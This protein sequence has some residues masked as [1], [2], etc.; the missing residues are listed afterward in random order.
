MSVFLIALFALFCFATC[1]QSDR[2][3]SDRNDLMSRDKPQ[4]CSRKE[5]ERLLSG[6]AT[7]V[8]SELDRLFTENPIIKFNNMTIKK[9]DIRD[10]IQK[11]KFK[12]LVNVIDR[13]VL[14][15][16]KK[17]WIDLLSIANFKDNQCIVG[18]RR[19]VI[20]HMQE[21]KIDSWEE[22][23]FPLNFSQFCSQQEILKLQNSVKDLQFLK[24]DQSQG[25]DRQS[26]D[27]DDRQRQGGDRQR[28]PIETDG[29]SHSQ[30]SNINKQPDSTTTSKSSAS[31]SSQSQDTSKPA[32]QEKVVEKEQPSGNQTE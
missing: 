17:C 32:V 16:N 15:N 12:T 2:L 4:M 18:A 29:S 20:L 23:M 26:I 13:P 3:S 30:S 11:M 5:L 6:D 31:S 10:V 25:S 21:E 27:R 19:V 28:R 1:Q 7:K 9:T 22:V 8:Y 14:Y 24:K